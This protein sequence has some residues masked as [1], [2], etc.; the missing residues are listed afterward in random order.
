MKD[1]GVKTQ[2]D[3][4]I[5]TK[6]E[7]MGNIKFTGGLHIDG[8]ITGN[9]VADEQSKA[10]L[11]ISDKG[12]VEGQI[13]VP[14]VIVNGTINGDIHCNGHL[15]LAPK[16]FIH[17]NIYYNTLEMVMGA[18]VNGQLHHHYFP[19]SQGNKPSLPHQGQNESLLLDA[20]KSNADDLQNKE[21]KDGK[22]SKEK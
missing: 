19:D 16:A 12:L 9:I 20:K 6:S 15:E 14:Y 18:Q 1:G 17:G 22:D 4:L 10:V 2:F 7:L 8:K 5:S 11:R 3:T 21:A 13:A